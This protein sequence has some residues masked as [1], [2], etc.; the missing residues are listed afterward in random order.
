MSTDRY[1]GRSHDAEKQIS[2]RATLTSFAENY[3]KTLVFER[4]DFL[5]L[6][7]LAALSFLD[8]HCT[9]AFV[10]RLLVT[11]ESMSRNVA[12]K[13]T[14]A[15][16]TMT[17]SLNFLCLRTLCRCKVMITTQLYEAAEGSTLSLHRVLDRSFDAEA[18]VTQ[19]S[20]FIVHR[21]PGLQNELEKVERPTNF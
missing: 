19:Q 5:N 6:E 14:R 16:P 3:Q 2:Y 7:S 13:D 15:S 18:E 12:S 9:R 21:L 10:V 8:V 20:I 4:R 1:W 17:K 11:A